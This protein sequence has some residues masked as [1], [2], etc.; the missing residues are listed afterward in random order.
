VKAACS[1]LVAIAAA[2][3]AGVALADAALFS[4]TPAEQLAAA[5]ARLD[6]INSYRERREFIPG[7]EV[8]LVEFSGKLQRWRA[9]IVKRGRPGTI[10]TIWDGGRS[11]RREMPFSSQ[12]ECFPSIP[13]SAVNPPTTVHDAG[14]LV[15][16]GK[17]ARRLVEEFMAEYMQAP[18]KVTHEVDI[19]AAT[20]IPIRLIS[21]EHP[22]G[23]PTKYVGTY[24]D[25][26][27][28]IQ[29]EFPC[30]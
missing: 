6:K 10:E 20:G 3:A 2:S 23:M 25:L 18:H 16:D 30:P 21:T 7:G 28:P 8:V 27:A 22:P 4:G 19:D 15:V 26:G 17:P 13:D 1:V 14:A 9:Q 12:W 11:A 24:Y 5:R 29:L